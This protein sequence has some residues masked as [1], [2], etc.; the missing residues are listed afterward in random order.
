M[1]DQRINS[2]ST[3]RVLVIAGIIFS[4][5]CWYFSNGLNEDSWYLLWIAPIPILVISFKATGKM[6]FIISFIAYLIGRLSWFSYLLTVA[7]IV[8]AIIFTLALSLFFAL[9]MIITRRTVIKTN[10]WYSVFAFPVFFTTFEFLL[11][12]FSAD[13][14]AGSIAYSQSNFLPVIQIA[15]VTGILGVTFLVTFVPS[16]VAVGW[17]YRS[18]KNK[19]RYIVSAAV[20]IMVSVFLF[21]IIRINNNSEKNTMKVGLVV[22]DE[23]FHN[24][25]DR[26]DFQKEKLVAELYTKEVS[27]LAAQGAQLIVLPERAINITKETG[28]SIISILSNAAKQNHVFIITGYTNFRNDPERNSALV[29]NAEGNPI[30]DYNKVHL[31]KG[32]ERQFTPGSEPGLFTL[33]EAQEGIAICKDLDFPDYIKRYG[34]GNV[35]FLCIPA[36]DFVKDDWLHSR[37]A[38]LRG[39]E[40]G[41][42]EIRTARLGRLTISDCY[43][44]VTSEANSSNGRRTALTGKVSLQKRNTVY[45]RF[46]DWFGMINLIAAAVFIF[47]GRRKKSKNNNIASG[48]A[49]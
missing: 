46:G 32:L 36:W 5:L 28:D 1:G 25:T 24:I 7:T 17:Y 16:V 3:Q 8:P 38:I 11:L 12:Q 33:N 35:S 42:S 37:M 39:V 18:K 10:S 23:K 30:A 2:F 34:K 22:L 21:G 40:N 26:P 49:G 27:D 6:T 48:N 13:G 20:I 15:S 14:T 44:R 29:I 4:G 31:V 9:V 41:F 19:F 47:S 43:G 45:T